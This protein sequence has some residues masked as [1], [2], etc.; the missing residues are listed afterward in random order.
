MVVSDVMTE[1]PA[2]AQS[3]D[4]LRSVIASLLELDVRH[5]PILEEGQ[6]VGIISDR[7]LRVVTRPLIDPETGEG[8]LE[9]I[10]DQP[11]SKV[12]S[13]DV[14]S[15]DPETELSEVIDI[16]M[17]HR[18]GAV[19][20]VATHTQDLVGIVSYIDILKAASESL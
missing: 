18:I 5:L 9:V 12:M 19:P 10:L 20:V 3:T 4:T 13:S 16:M 2:T 17:E 8:K 11:V 7:D 6:L 15:V 14:I 1:S